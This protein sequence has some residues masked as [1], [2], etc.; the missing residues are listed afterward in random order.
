[1]TRRRFLVVAAAAVFAGSA[2]CWLY[3]DRLTVEE[4]AFVG[5][6]L[7]RETYGCVNDGPITLKL[8][9]GHDC[10]RFGKD[11]PSYAATGRWWVRDGHVCLDFEPSGFR[12]VLRPLMDR[13]GFA[14]A[15]VEQMDADNFD[16]RGTDRTRFVRITVPIPW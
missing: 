14:V 16:F 6:W 8:D 7:L 13:F 3:S 15:S 1:M 10:A 11:V 4:E 9:R 5:E 2:A 12:R